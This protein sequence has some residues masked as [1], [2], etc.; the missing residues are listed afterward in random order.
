M[1]LSLSESATEIADGGISVSAYA[2]DFAT[3]Y[4]D[5]SAYADS[6]AEADGVVTIFKK[7]WEPEPEPEPVPEPCDGWWCHEPEP[8]PE[9]E[10]EPCDGWW[11]DSHEDDSRRSL[12]E[13][14]VETYVTN[15]ASATASG[16]SSS[17][18]G[19][20]NADTESNTFAMGDDALA[21]ATALSAASGEDWWGEGMALSLSESATEIADGGISVSAYADDFAT[22][23]G[24]WSAY[25]DSD[26]TA[27]G[28]VL[29][30]K[31]TKHEP[32][33]APEPVPEPCD[34]W[35]CHEDK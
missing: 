20:V 35:W 28:A 7:Y 1:A 4:G 30:H 11:C 16:S 26:A 22:T 18:P 10:P 12:K 15:V 29:Y 9:P 27:S 13:H 31:Y 34:G 21:E 14:H 24:D 19:E 25:A 23:Y 6:D 2:D 17:T 33:P 5:W 8:Y 3:T 32:E